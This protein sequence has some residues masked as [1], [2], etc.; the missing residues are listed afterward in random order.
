MVSDAELMLQPPEIVVSGRSFRAVVETSFKQDLYI[1]SLVEAAGLNDL[2]SEIDFTSPDLPNT[3]QRVIARAFSKGQLFA[4]LGA[5]VE[6]VGEEWTIEGAKEREVFFGNLRKAEDKKA[7]H[8]AIVVIILGFFVN[9]LLSSK[10]S[11][12]SLIS[13]RDA[14]PEKEATEAQETSDSGISLS[15]RLPVIIPSDTTL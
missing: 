15:D 9:G 2:A 11:Q 12:V 10:T 6:E 5:V 8:S 3:A 14:E 4:L 13:R 7:L 1:M